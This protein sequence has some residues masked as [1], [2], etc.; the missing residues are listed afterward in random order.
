MLTIYS[1]TTTTLTRLVTTT[2][3]YSSIMQQTTATFRTFATHGRTSS[4]KFTVKLSL[5]TKQRHGR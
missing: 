5:I 3:V 4:S 1:Y 2:F